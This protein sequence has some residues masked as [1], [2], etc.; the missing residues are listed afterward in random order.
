MNRKILH[1]AKYRFNYTLNYIKYYYFGKYL[2]K[3]IYF[4]TLHKCASTLFS[5]FVLKNVNK[6]I[7]V[8]YASQI[9]T[10]KIQIGKQLSFKEKGF[11]YGPL[12]IQPARSQC[13]QC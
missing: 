5:D 2:P 4:Y 11:I 6:L 8:D 3:S 7:H 10:G 12:R 1:R 13:L 9:F